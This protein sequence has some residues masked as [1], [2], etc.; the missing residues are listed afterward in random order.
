MGVFTF[1]VE[2]LF[3]VPLLFFLSRFRLKSELQ[4]AGILTFTATVVITF[5]SHRSMTSI[6]PDFIGMPFASFK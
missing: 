5:D 3:H 4:L 6:H 1:P 2:I